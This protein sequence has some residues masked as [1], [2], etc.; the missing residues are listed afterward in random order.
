MEFALLG[1]LEVRRGAYLVG[2]GA[3]R[4]RLILTVLLLAA[5]TVVPS[6]RLVDS[7][8]GDDPPPT[9]KHSVQV[10]L[11]R[12]RAALETGGDERI[13]TRG[14]GYLIRM[15]PGELDL[16]RMHTLVADAESHARRGDH[17][18]ALRRYE[19][20]AALWRGPPLEE[21]SGLPW[22]DATVVALEHDHERFVEGDLASRLALGHGGEIVGVLESL[23]QANPGRERLRGQLMLALYQAGRQSDALAAFTDARGYLRDEFGLDPGPELRELHQRI[24]RHEASVAPPRPA[25]PHESPPEQPGEHPAER[26]VV[27]I[28]AA[29]MTQD[30]DD[31]EQLARAVSRFHEAFA[32]HVTSTGGFVEELTGGTSRACFGAD[33]TEDHADRAVAAALMLRDDSAVGP[34]GIGVASG[35]VLRGAASD[36]PDSLRQPARR[37]TGRPV[38]YAEALAHEAAPGCVL[39]EASVLAAAHG[40]YVVGP[41][42][43]LTPSGMTACIVLECSSQRAERAVAGLNRCFLGRE[44]ELAAIS[45]TYRAV[46]REGEPRLVTILGDAGIGKSALLQAARL[47]LAAQDPQPRILAGQCVAYGRGITYRALAE[48]LRSILGISEDGSVAEALTALGEQ[49]AAL[50]PVFGTDTLE[51]VHPAAARERLGAGWVDLLSRLCRATPVVILLEDIHWAELPFLELMDRVVRDTDGPLLLIASARPEHADHPRVATRRTSTQWLEPLSRSSTEELV[52]QLLGTP[53]PPSLTDI[54][55]ERAEGFPFYVE[56]LLATLIERQLLIRRTDGGWDYLGSGADIVP[57]NIRALLAARVDLLAAGQ[58]SVL[59]AAS[60]FGRRFDPRTVSR[61]T[62]ALGVDFPGLVERDLL[63]R[64]RAGSAAGPD[65]GQLEFK[66]AL[67]RDVAYASIPRT[68]RVHLHA[69]IARDLE[70]NAT[71]DDDLAPILAHHF[72][73][74]ARGD[75]ATIAWEGRDGELES[76]RRS[77]VEWLI[78][79]GRLCI[80]RSAIDEGISLLEQALAFEPA[81]DVQADAWRAI[82]RGHAL[83]YDGPRCWAA[84]LRAVEL[85]RDEGRRGAAFA[86]LAMETVSR[87]GM[88]D[89]P[90]RDLVSSWIDRAVALADDDSAARAQALIARTIWFPTDARTSAAEAVAA[91]ERLGDPALRSHAYCARAAVSYIAGDYADADRWADRMLALVPALDDPDV[92]VDVYGGTV[93]S[94]LGQGQFD[95]ARKYVEEHGAVAWT[96]SDHHRVHAV[97]MHLEL[98][99]VAGNWQAIRALAAQTEAIVAANASTP[100]QRNARSPLVCAYAFLVG[101]DPQRAGYYES[102]AEE[103]AL[104]GHSS[105]LNPMRLRLA[106]A[107]GDLDAARRFVRPEPPPPPWKHWYQ[108][109]TSTIRLDA[110]CALGEVTAVEREAAAL[111]RPGTYLE[112]FALEALGRVRADQALL[113]AAIAGYERLGLT[114]QHERARA[115]IGAHDSPMTAS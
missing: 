54:V 38:A 103:Q 16:D 34:V 65:T 22:A 36:G 78:R 20:V 39:V 32:R 6:S 83:R 13:V 30:S 29:T 79:A 67:T 11:S 31:P 9:A 28:L 58:K 84:M 46:V 60:A 94:L 47:S 109:V 15:G 68:R 102:L 4:E 90:D 73:I 108:L 59:Q 26:R 95:R 18:S 113:E 110:L 61:V 3:P 64:R 43:R 44:T 66:H 76:L 62:G 75:D 27:S 97:S 72:A 33:S 86:E 63:R 105:I 112:P 10:S 81:A 69:A 55:L 101:G 17:R 24:L 50:A 51:P 19:A 91:A 99:E 96:L 12:L 21:F 2:L 25:G 41:E 107:R 42:R 92:I 80:A 85:Y 111:L 45:D 93:P 1:P 115:S 52:D 100:C 104:A 37:S 14:S 88:M 82:G 71:S 77:A 57:D 106:L 40:R 7:V 89:M 48:V 114:W 5:N 8:W 74:A 70:A 98:E 87:Y 49:G 56:E 53:A 23:V 35:E